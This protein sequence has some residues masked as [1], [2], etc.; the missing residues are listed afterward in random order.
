MIWQELTFRPVYRRLFLYC[1]QWGKCLSV[2][3][4]F[5]VAVPWVAT[6]KNR[7][8]AILP[9]QHTILIVHPWSSPSSERCLY[10]P[11]AGWERSFSPAHRCRS[12]CEFL[13]P[14]LEWEPWANQI[15]LILNVNAVHANVRCPNKNEHH[16]P[17]L[18][19]LSEDLLLVRR[20]LTWLVGKPPG[21]T[22][23]CCLFHNNEF[24]STCSRPQWIVINIYYSNI[25][26]VRYDNYVTNYV[27]KRIDSEL[28]YIIAAANGLLTGFC[29]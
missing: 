24:K 20:S 11:R 10:C 16:Q 22:L 1:R 15:S 14:S 25:S 12:R 6:R 9:V 21:E 29:W 8:A 4:N 5:H 26:H 17:S 2:K 19:S 23:K 13:A 28:N 18:L 3:M 27:T 7:T